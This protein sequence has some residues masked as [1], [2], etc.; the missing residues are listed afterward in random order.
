LLAAIIEEMRTGEPGGEAV[1]ERLLT[2]LAA[3]RAPAPTLNHYAFL[4]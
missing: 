4:C 2:H 3:S 1:C